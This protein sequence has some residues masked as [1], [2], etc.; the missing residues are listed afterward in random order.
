[1]VEVFQRLDVDAGVALLAAYARPKVPRD[2]RLR[3]L[4]GARARGA[5]SLRIAWSTDGDP[6]REATLAFP[7]G[8]PDIVT[9]EVR[10]PD[11]EYD[12]EVEIDTQEGRSAARKRVTLSGATATL[13][14]R[15]ER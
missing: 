4:L 6:L 13:D 2:Q 15:D 5:R 11:G 10:L 8:A 9:H 3:V 14:L 1:R 7:G 12:V